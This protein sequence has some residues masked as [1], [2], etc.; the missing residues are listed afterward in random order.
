MT[1]QGS[2][3]YHVHTICPLPRSYSIHVLFSVC[4]LLPYIGG[5]LP[6]V[7]SR[8]FPHGILP[9]PYTVNIVDVYHAIS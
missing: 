3:P 5:N 7:R 4:V 9:R 1:I 2:L 8:R 6:K